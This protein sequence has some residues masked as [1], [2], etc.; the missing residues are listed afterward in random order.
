VES[1]HAIAGGG[2]GRA[3]DKCLSVEA[4][5]GTIYSETHTRVRVGKRKRCDTTLMN[6]MITT[7]EWI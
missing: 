4:G 5:D 1:K 2:G 7:M 6:L 3:I